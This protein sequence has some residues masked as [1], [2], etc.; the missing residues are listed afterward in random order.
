MLVVGEKDYLEN[1]VSVHIHG[2][3]DNGMILISEF[4]ANFRKELKII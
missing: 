2:Q 3:G 1:K 4:I